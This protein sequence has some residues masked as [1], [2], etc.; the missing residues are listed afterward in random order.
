[1][2]SV[3]S[4][5]FDDY[6]NRCFYE[7]ENGT[8]P[9]EKFRIRIYNGNTNHITLE[10]KR[11]ENGL[12][13][14]LSCPLTPLQ[15]VRI[16]E[17]NFCLQDITP[18]ALTKSQY[19]ILNKFY[20]L[21]ST[22]FFRAKV[23]VEYERTAYT[24]DIGSVRITFDRNISSSKYVQGFMS[25]VIPM[26]PVLAQGKHVLEIKYDELLPNHLYHA[27]Q[28]KNLRQTT[29]SKYYISRKFHL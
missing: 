23:I 9:R 19:E 10:C 3:K 6:S 2:Y 14:K 4:V 15:C 21:Y 24:Y 11:K 27:L 13:Y 7:N 22:T 12:N 20:I 25:P 5:Y 28:L 8:N 17:G 16:L 26:R 18:S 29:F 1:M